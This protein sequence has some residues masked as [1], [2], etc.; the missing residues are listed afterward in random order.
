VKSIQLLGQWVL[1]SEPAPRARLTP[2]SVSTLARI[3]D[4]IFVLFELTRTDNMLC[5]C[6]YQY[7]FWP[8][9]PKQV[10]STEKQTDVPVLSPDSGFPGMLPLRFPCKTAVL[11][12]GF[13][14]P[15]VSQC[16][17]DPGN[18]LLRNRDSR[19]VHARRS[20]FLYS[21]QSVVLYQ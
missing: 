8:F 10:S 6:D 11:E 17:Q 14:F 9:H 16:F 12:I 19:G 21:D 18:E 15:T 1:S 3:D 2:S 4:D 5:L 20:G 13:I 7:T